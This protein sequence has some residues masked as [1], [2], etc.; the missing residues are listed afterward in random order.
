MGVN[1]G[2][3]NDTDALCDSE[4]LEIVESPIASSR[5]PPIAPHCARTMAMSSN[6]LFSL[7]LGLI[8]DLMAF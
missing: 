3:F 4:K 5:Y 1:A 8:C 2:I 7:L 6:L